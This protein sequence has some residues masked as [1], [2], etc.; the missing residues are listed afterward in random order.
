MKKEFM[1]CIRNDEKF[2]S[3]TDEQIRGWYRDLH[4]YHT[5]ILISFLKSKG[6]HVC[7][8]EKIV[9]GT[10][11]SVWDGEGEITSRAE[12]N[13]F[14]H[15]VNV[16]KSYD[17][18]E[19]ETEDGYPFECEILEDEYVRIDGKKYPCTNKSSYMDCDDENMFWYK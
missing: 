13:L 19:L 14:T 2:K 6:L 15:E 8:S 16:L 18:A 9:P 12:I 4:E 7:V 3:Y 17:P 10:Y 1:D 5:N 11:T